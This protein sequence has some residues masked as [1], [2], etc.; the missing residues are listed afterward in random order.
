MTKQDLIELSYQISRL[1]DRLSANKMEKIECEN[2]LLKL[3]TKIAE[4]DKKLNELLK[5]INDTTR[6]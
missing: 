4:D 6:T 5:Q 1:C 3:D 2:R